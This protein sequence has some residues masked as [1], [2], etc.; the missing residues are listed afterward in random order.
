[1]INKNDIISFLRANLP[2]LR[3]YYHIVRI[4]LFGSFARNEQGDDSDI[5]IIVE[6][7]SGTPDIH[8]LKLEL[9]D[10]IGK[11]FNRS[12]DIAREKYLKPYA[13][14]AILSEV[15]YVQ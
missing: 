10:F 5:D 11:T 14:N 3:S 12:V 9:E 4:G 1:M 2:V 7:E 13:R 15:I 8:R 6:I